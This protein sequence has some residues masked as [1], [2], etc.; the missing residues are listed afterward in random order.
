[1]DILGICF[2]LKSYIAQKFYFRKYL[3]EP[4]YLI[5]WFNK[6]ITESLIIIQL[7]FSG[8]I[9]LNSDIIF[10]NMA[11]SA[12]NNNSIYSLFMMEYRNFSY[13]YTSLCT[14]YWVSKYYFGYIKG[15]EK[16]GTENNL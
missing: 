4:L 5:Y 7:V 2:N 6:S 10:T 14:C 3:I 12:E 9:R 16:S 8:V 11:C 13:Y 15:L 1:M